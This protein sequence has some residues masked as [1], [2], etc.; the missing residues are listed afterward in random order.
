[1]IGRV[2]TPN[3]PSAAFNF[4][5]DGGATPVFTAKGARPRPDPRQDRH[6][7]LADRDCALGVGTERYPPRCSDGSP[8]TAIAVASEETVTCTFNNV[9]QTGKLEVKKSL[10]PT[11]DPGKFDLQI[12]GTT[13]PNADDVSNNGSTGEETKHRDPHRR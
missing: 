3:D 11:T 13:D 7:P 9:R 4:F 6:H 2:A 10:S 12:D 1:M 8:I 5:L